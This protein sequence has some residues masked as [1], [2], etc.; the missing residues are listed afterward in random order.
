[1]SGQTGAPLRYEI[2]PSLQIHPPSRHDHHHIES[3]PHPLRQTLS[4]MVPMP[5]ARHSIPVGLGTE[6]DSLSIARYYAVDNEC[7]DNMNNHLE[8]RVGVRGLGPCMYYCTVYMQAGQPGDLADICSA[9][10]VHPQIL[11]PRFYIKE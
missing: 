9:C 10:R 1:M 2:V 4:V 5:S 3:H 8:K 11:D 7:E 6:W